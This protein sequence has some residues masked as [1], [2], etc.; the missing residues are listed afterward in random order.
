MNFPETNRKTRLGAGFVRFLWR[1]IF[2]S[3]GI[4]III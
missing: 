4:F 3:T 2:F 1:K